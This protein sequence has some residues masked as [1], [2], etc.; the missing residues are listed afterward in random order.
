LGTSKLS[1]A[2]AKLTESQS[3]SQYDR[4]RA[5]I[6]AKTRNSSADVSASRVAFGFAALCPDTLAPR[7]LVPATAKR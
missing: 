5:K 2:S 6:A 4:V 3:S 7:P 1:S